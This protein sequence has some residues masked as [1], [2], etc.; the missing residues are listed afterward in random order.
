MGLLGWLYLDMHHARAPSPG[1]SFVVV[2]PFKFHLHSGTYMYDV[3][4]TFH[5][6]ANENPIK[7]MIFQGGKKPGIKNQA[8]YVE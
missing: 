7:T 3:G 4:F 1:R 6:V 2:T 8:C 5:R